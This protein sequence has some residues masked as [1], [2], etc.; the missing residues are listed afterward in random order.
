MVT[1]SVD[2]DNQQNKHSKTDLYDKNIRNP[3]GNQTIQY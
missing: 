2:L 3:L 1:C